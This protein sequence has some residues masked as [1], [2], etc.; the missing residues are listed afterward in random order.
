MRN[1]GGGRLPDQRHEVSPFKR[2]WT[3][4]DFTGGCSPTCNRVAAP[5][6][7]VCGAK[8]QSAPGFLP[9]PPCQIRNHSGSNSLKMS[10][11]AGLDFDGP[12]SHHPRA[13]PVPGHAV[14]HPC[15][16]RSACHRRFLPSFMAASVRRWRSH[17]FR[18]PVGLGIRPSNKQACSRFGPYG[19]QEIRLFALPCGVA[20]GSRL[21]WVK[22]TPGKGFG[23]WARAC[24]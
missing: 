3:L 6:G 13:M 7:K 15:E 17:A 4:A 12:A 1:A 24:G 2:H 5:T 22:L 23:E 18:G 9:A 10:R 21:R 14:L 20:I 8:R 11:H 19:P 16:L